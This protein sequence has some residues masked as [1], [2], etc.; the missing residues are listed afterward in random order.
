VTWQLPTMVRDT[1][2]VDHLNTYWSLEVCRLV[3]AWCDLHFV[4]KTLQ[5]LR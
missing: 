2:V 4:S 3:A 5:A 1:W